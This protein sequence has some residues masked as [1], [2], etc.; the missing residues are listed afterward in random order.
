MS[1]QVV[2]L[3]EAV[4]VD[5]PA[6]VPM[7]LSLNGVLYGT[8]LPLPPPPFDTEAF[9]PKRLVITH[10]AGLI[11]TDFNG[12][13]DPFRFQV[14]E[15]RDNLLTVRPRDDIVVEGGLAVILH[16]NHRNYKRGWEILGP[17]ESNSGETDQV[18][19][20]IDAI[21]PVGTTVRANVIL[22]GAWK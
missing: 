4:Q 1:A 9:P 18:S 17:R 5:G 3:A 12:P 16:Q 8:V 19:L 14:N 21:L 10:I 13:F 15:S 2:I 7:R 6:I 20:T 22:Q 11:F